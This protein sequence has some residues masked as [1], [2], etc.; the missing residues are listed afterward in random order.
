VL[1]DGMVY[2]KD[3]NPRWIDNARKRSAEEAAEA[4]GP[5]VPPA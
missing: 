4:K 2:Q 5:V 1:G 3:F